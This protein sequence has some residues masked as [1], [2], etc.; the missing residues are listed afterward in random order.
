MSLIQK[1]LA[2]LKRRPQAIEP[3]ETKLSLT[4]EGVEVY[5]VEG[6]PTGAVR[7][8]AP[9]HPWNPTDTNILVCDLVTYVSLAASPDSQRLVALT[10]IESLRALRVKER[11]ALRRQRRS[12]R[13]AASSA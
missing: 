2:L 11:S 7:F 4:I 13:R 1:C 10:V 12:E 5:A 9:G 6:M 8:L 3:A